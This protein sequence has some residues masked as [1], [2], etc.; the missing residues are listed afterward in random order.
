VLALLLVKSIGGKLLFQTRRYLLNVF[1]IKCAR[2][3]DVVGDQLEQIGTDHRET[4]VNED[5]YIF[6]LILVADEFDLH[7]SE[8]KIA[9][10]RGMVVQYTDL[11]VM[12]RKYHGS[13]LT[14]HDFSRRCDNNT[15][16][17]FLSSQRST[18]SYLLANI[19]A[20]CATSSIV[21]TY[22]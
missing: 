21:P 14:I 11:A 3:Y 19:L 15:I 18:F 8:S 13:R 9:E 12:R 20:F 4:A 6:H 2:K 1:R 7:D 10:H 22:I 16:E 5:E 17:R